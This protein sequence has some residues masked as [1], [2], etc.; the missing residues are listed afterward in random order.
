MVFFFFSSFPF[1]NE[2]QFLHSIIVE[3]C[4]EHSKKRIEIYTNDEFLTKNSKFDIYNDKKRSYSINV[5]IKLIN[6]KITKFSCK[7]ERERVP[8]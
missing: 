2:P 6:S 1:A 3:I 5:R 4:Y 8:R 7:K